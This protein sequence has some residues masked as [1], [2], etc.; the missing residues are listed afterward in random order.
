MRA[1]WISSGVLI[2]AAHFGVLYGFTALA[3][4]RG[5]GGAVPWVAGG[6][7]LA[8]LLGLAWVLRVHRRDRGEFVS[9]MTLSVA[10]LA[11]VAVLYETVPFFIVPT[12]A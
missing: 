2:W 4:A 12:C 7:T 6:A 10:G 8:A 5:L 1:L 9:W 3:C 11:L